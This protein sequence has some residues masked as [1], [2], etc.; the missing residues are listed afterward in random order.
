MLSADD[1]VLINETRAKGFEAKKVQ[2]KIC[3]M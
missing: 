1:L 2:D 3:G